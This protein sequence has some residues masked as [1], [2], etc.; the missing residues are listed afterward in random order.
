[1]ARALLL[2]LQWH[3]T[4]SYAQERMCLCSIQLASTSAC[5]VAVASP[6]VY[7]HSCNFFFDGLYRAVVY[8]EIRAIAGQPMVS[9]TSRLHRCLPA[10]SCQFRCQSDRV[11]SSA[12]VYASHPV[13]VSRFDTVAPILAS[14]FLPA[15]VPRVYT[16]C[17]L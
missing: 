10:C 8:V 12:R 17:L 4:C 16:P 14:T 11:P 2:L 3:P 7:W 6:V 9:A 1:M 15:P 13:N 5:Q